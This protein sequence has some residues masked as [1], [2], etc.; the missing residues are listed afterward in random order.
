M[1]TGG[2]V[3]ACVRRELAESGA[4]SRDLT[5]LVN[6]VLAILPQYGPDAACAALV[7]TDEDVQKAVDLLLT[8]PLPGGRSKK[9]T[10]QAGEATSREAARQQTTGASGQSRAKPGAPAWRTGPSQPKARSQASGERAAV[11][12]IQ[13]S[14]ARSRDRELLASAL[15]CWSWWVRTARVVEAQAS[16]NYDDVNRT[17]PREDDFSNFGYGEVVEGGPQT[18]FDCDARG[19]AAIRTRSQSCDSYAGWTP[20]CDPHHG[21]MTSLGIV[22]NGSNQVWEP[23]WDMAMQASS[24]LDEVTAQDMKEV[25]GDVPS[26]FDNV[27]DG[28]LGPGVHSHENQPSSN[29]PMIGSADPNEGYVAVAMPYIQI[30]QAPCTLTDLDDRQ[31]VEGLAASNRTHMRLLMTAHQVRA[32]LFGAPAGQRH[33]LCVELYGSLALYGP[34]QSDLHMVCQQDWARHYVRVNSDIDIV[35]L[36][37]EGGIATDVMQSLVQRGTWTLVNQTHV[38]KFSITQFTL[39]GT[40]ERAASLGIGKTHQLW[41]DLTCIDNEEEYNRF[42]R[43]QQAFMHT[44]KCIRAKLEYMFGP[45]GALAFD[46]YIYLLKGFAQPLQRNA[47]TGFQATCFGLLCLQ[48]GLYE[49]KCCEPTGLILFECFL[50]FCSSFFS[51]DP[52]QSKH[53][54]LR[55]YRHC[56]VDFSLGG[57]MLPRMNAKWP[58]EAYFLNCEVQMQTQPTD[59]V[60]IAHSIDPVAVCDAARETLKRTASIKEGQLLWAETS[61][62]CN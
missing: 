35:V 30:P 55:N 31:I 46:A 61:E 2:S 37:K 17:A 29:P 16:A 10:A 1:Q 34:H 52:A 50:R 41:L 20:Q 48:L 8:R 24:G 5:H 28:G 62:G 47:M 36:L 7:E 22:G 54:R 38:P 23:A 33:S 6:E 15:D 26:L 42:K 13:T 11:S 40:D 59:R 60:N 39:S 53:N 51:D 57:R 56:A 19:S 9:G 32:L 58:C 25:W 18:A 49:L 4:A 45:N 3:L 12:K 43:R 27:G 21:F 14:A 44:F